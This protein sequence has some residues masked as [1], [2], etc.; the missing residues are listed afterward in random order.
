M[1]DDEQPTGPAQRRA[2]NPGSQS[3]L[4]SRNQQRLTQQLLKGGPAT[5]ADLARS[6]GLSTAT[7]SNIV[8]SMAA[9]DLVT[10]TP[11][12]SSGR[13]AM[14]VR[15]NG[16]SAIAAGIDFGRSHVRVVLANTGYHVLAE[17][18]APLPRGHQ[19]VEGI[20][21]ASRLLDKLLKKAGISRSQLIGAGAGIPG[22]ID[23][24]S[25]K[26]IRGAILPEWVGINLHDELEK[27]LKIPVFVDNDANLG[28]L[29]QLTW[30]DQ[31][32][33]SNLMFVKI[34]TG[35]GA[36]L[37]LQGALF[38]GSFGVTGE[39]GHVTI[40]EHGLICR[41]GNRGC[42]E[43]VASTATMVELLSRGQDRPIS[44]AD[45]LSQ[46]MSGDPATLRVLD[47][48]GMAI[49]RALANVANLISPDVIVIGGPLT[50]LGDLLL[51]PIRRGLLRHA[52]PVIGDSIGLKMS[53]LTS[54][55]EALGAAALVFQ[56]EPAPINS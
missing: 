1:L 27:A 26:V 36:G 28:A 35:I 7:V 50:E 23:S 6:T 13:R 46:A 9:A 32:N 40:D 55:A 8:K 54:R 52:V 30:G 42:L 4:R 29:A 33:V 34:G 47:D 51:A 45:I 56:H 53:H 38:H 2:R 25:G 12:T 14:S 37:I 48:A 43:T 10:L 44:T 41:C 15:Y 39:I 31:G 3:A 17:E 16:D 22:P 19:A 24:R 5:Q 18:E 20:Q 49:G 21:T 11:V